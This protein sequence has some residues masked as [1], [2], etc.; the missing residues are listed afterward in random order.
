[1]SAPVVRVEKMTDG[2][3]VWFW[4]PGCETHHRITFPRWHFNGDLVK[5]TLTPSVL[6]TYEDGPKFTPK[7]CHLY[8][9]NGQLHFLNDSTHA[10]AGRAV[11]MSPI[12]ESMGDLR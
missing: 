9:T 12:A 6:V 8:V 2:E 4:C 7:R 10:L 11:E 3:S 1:M 5:P